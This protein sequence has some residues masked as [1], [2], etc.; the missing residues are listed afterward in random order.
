MRQDKFFYDEAGRQKP[1]PGI[2]E[3]DDFEGIDLNE[4]LIRNPRESFSMVVNSDAMEEAGIFRGDM[5]IVDRAVE[6]GSGHVVIAVLDGEMLIRRLEISSARRQ[7]LPATSKLSAIEIN[8]G[9]SFRVWGV[10]TYV[11]HSV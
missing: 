8:P 6:P 7:L 9:A 5:V 11:I 3:Q 1:L 4:Q 2:Q 10:V